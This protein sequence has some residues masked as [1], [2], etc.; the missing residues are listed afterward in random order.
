MKEEVGYFLFWAGV[1][2]IVGMIGGIIVS[3][4]FVL[5]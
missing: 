5:I 2:L 1:H 4:L 3:L